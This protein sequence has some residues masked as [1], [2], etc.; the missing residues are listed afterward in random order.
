MSNTNEEFSIY[1]L[2]SAR[3]IE[4]GYTE[5]EIADPQQRLDFAM[6]TIMQTHSMKGK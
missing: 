1:E 4:S 6:R 5:E 2:V 3:M